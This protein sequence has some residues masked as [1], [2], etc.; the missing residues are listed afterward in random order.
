MISI[1]SILLSLRS[2]GF[3]NTFRIAQYSLRKIWLDNHYL[4]PRSAALPQTPGKLL[5]VSINERGGRFK[6]QYATLDVYFLADDIV[7]LTWE[8]GKAPVP[9]AVTPQDWPIPDLKIIH[10]NGHHK[11][12]TPNV[13]VI[14]EQDGGVSYFNSQGKLMRQELLPIHHGPGWEIT[15]LLQPGE[16]FYG[17]GEQAG[18]LDLHKGNFTR[19]LWNTDPGGSY[20]PGHDPIYMP[21]PV[22]LSAHDQGSYLLFHENH[23]RG[24]FRFSSSTGNPPPDQLSISFQGGNL[25]SYFFAGPPPTAL[26]R[27]TQLTGRAPLPPLWS[28]GYHQCRWGYHNAEIV[29]Q[30]VAGFQAHDMPLQVIHLD[31]DYMD[32]F[33][34][35]TVD[36]TRFPDLGDLSR[37]LDTKGV[38]LVTII[39][40]GVKQDPTYD[41][42][43]Q[44]IDKQAFINLQKG[45]PLSGLVW[46]AWSRYPDFTK[47]EVRHWWGQFYARLLDVGVAGIWHDMNEPVS[48]TV[49]CE[50]TFPLAASHY[51]EGQQ[52]DHLEAHNLY[53]MQMN[54]AAAEALSQLRPN[55][56]P[57]IISRSGWVGGQRYAWNWTGDTSST[58]DGLRMTIAT[59]LGLGLSGFPIYWS[60]YWW[61]QR[62]TRGR[63]LL[64]MVPDG[65]V[66]AIFSHPFIY[67]HRAS[68]TLGVR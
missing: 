59:V 11:F 4:R 36:K 67:R 38:R 1:Q 62:F 54:R 7:R 23:H 34:V 22:Y 13:S 55:R 44:G 27:F 41:V 14:L 6:F 64:A 50:M 24:V 32:G 63:T 15:T 10:E 33:R 2:T 18:P 47:P 60:G 9:Y 58:W 57:W 46:P 30:V 66:L 5:D 48:F 56:R 16:N 53:A 17:L 39:D 12:S 37:E 25:R 26:E 21:L 29:R 51:L 49:G 68:I 42:Y 52:G 8:P 28:L 40:P 35:F 19:Q 61:V 65:S 45:K 31:I 3:K 43:S 20:G